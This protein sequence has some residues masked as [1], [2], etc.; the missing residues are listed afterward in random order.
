M[1]SPVSQCILNNMTNLE[2][3]YLINL[4]LVNINIQ[5]GEE[6]I[7]QSLLLQNISMVEFSNYK[8]NELR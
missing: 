5:Q 7:L 1:N 2:T 4:P 6:L 3:L 8:L